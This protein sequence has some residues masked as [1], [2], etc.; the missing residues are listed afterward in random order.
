MSV[1]AIY[2]FLRYLSAKKSVD[3][4][5]LNR[6]VRDSLAAAIDSHPA[7]HRCDILELGAGIGTMV[8]RVLEWGL[9]RVATYTALDA[10]RACVIEAKKRLTRWAGRHAFPA[11]DEGPQTL[12]LG[13]QEQ[14]VYV[15]LEAAD[16]SEFLA[17][18]EGRPEW[19]LLIANAFLDLIDLAST[20]PRVLSLLRPNGL[21]Y[22]TI[23]FDGA[24]IFQPEIDPEFD[25][26]IEA[27]YHETMDR[28]VSG[29]KPSGDS[30]TG[31]HLFEQLRSA[32]AEI[33]DA[34][35][36]DWVVF[37]GSKGY[38][39]D[40]SY[41]LHHIVHTIGTA[42]DAH[43]DLDPGRFSPWI[44]ERH[45]QIEHGRLV[46]IAHQIDFLGRVRS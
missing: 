9:V 5:A 33:V 13:G 46:Y 30:R 7:G 29:A 24:T 19:D 45:A 28:R 4:R 32:G 18:H 6:H 11:T 43:P 42:L 31:R 14:H 38:P 26:R 22:F 10:D 2:D 44:S 37:P 35:A 36:S 8:E 34:G 15:K 40:E 25:R 39:E 41:F 27:L 21:F 12:R 23:N 17:R 20:V 3:D 16:L 1:P